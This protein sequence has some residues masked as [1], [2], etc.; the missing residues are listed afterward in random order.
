L[1]RTKYFYKRAKK[2]TKV[3][4]RLRLLMVLKRGQ[5][6]MV[7]IPEKYRKQQEIVWRTAT[8]DE[9]ALG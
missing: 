6:K 8:E 5:K 7:P 2:M 3:W 1:E 4:F 9:E